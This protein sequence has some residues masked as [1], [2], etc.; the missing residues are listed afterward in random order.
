[1][2]ESTII[3]N[4][5][6]QRIERAISEN[7]FPH[8]IFINGSEG[9]GALPIAIAIANELLN[10]HKGPGLFGETGDIR[11]LK[12]EHPDLHF[13]FPIQQLQSKNQVTS[14]SFINEF[15]NYYRNN[16]F[17][18]FQNWL[19]HIG[20]EDKSPIISVYEAESIIR[21][22]SL[23]SYEGGNQVLIIWKPDLM[24]LECANKLL[25][26]IEEPEPGHII[27]M[28][29][30]NWD[31]LLPTIKSRTQHL[32]V[33]PF[34]DH[35]LKNWLIK[36]LDISEDKASE[37]SQFSYGNPSR[38]IDA[39]RSS[40]E[41]YQLN[42]FKKEWFSLVKAYNRTELIRWVEE[43]SSLSKNEKH[44]LLKSILDELSDEM[45][46]PTHAISYNNIEKLSIIVE[47]AMY[48]L[49]RNAYSKSLF[50][51]L[52]FQACKIFQLKS[53]SMG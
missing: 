46:I 13:V 39:L 19:V 1:M 43:V 4:Q 26:I 22:L 12:L 50:L 32:H 38:A 16:R 49:F 6:K 2:L 53:E 29:G 51:S 21:N 30:D 17:T 3:Q 48:H 23:K 14:A 27:L 45:K 7:R 47:D 11:A 36:E 37:I 10:Q 33:K 34:S 8:S 52:S 5:L 42:E 24:N 41:L 44:L 25:K 15:R 9:S 31:S 20:Q 35:E 40:N 28:V 18:T